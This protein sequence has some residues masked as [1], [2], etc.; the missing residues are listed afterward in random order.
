MYV[1]AVFG[2]FACLFVFFLKCYTALFLSSFGLLIKKT[3]DLPV[4]C[5]LV[6]GQQSIAS[7]SLHFL[8]WQSA[9]NRQK[10]HTPIWYDLEVKESEG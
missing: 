10:N 4:L 8:H 3:D 9:L 6:T 2:L 5:S 7:S 1:L